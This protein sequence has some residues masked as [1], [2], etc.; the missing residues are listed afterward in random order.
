MPH[1]LVYTQAQNHARAL[2]KLLLRLP[3]PSPKQ[4]LKVRQG[5]RFKLSSL[6]E[7]LLI[8]M[9]LKRQTRTGT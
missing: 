1:P 6:T 2:T 9:K 4:P 7:N 3:R 5:K 8:G